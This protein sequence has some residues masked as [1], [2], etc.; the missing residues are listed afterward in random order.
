MK[1]IVL[2]IVIFF[3]VWLFLGQ[4]EALPTTDGMKGYFAQHQVVLQRVNVEILAALSEG[5][6]M[7][8]ALAK[9]EVYQFLQ[10]RSTPMPM[11]NYHTHV[12][13]FGLGSYGTGIAYSPS[14]PEKIY[15]NLEVMRPD[16]AAVEG[17][18]GYTHISGD[19][20]AF[21]WEAD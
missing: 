13:G 18:V 20:Y 7:D 9:G 14:A 3:V 8:P 11:V 10:L 2:G 21:F 16:A 6:Q 19:W 5:K 17:F 15:E 4:E 1:I 12:K